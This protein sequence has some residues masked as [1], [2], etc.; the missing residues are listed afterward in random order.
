MARAGRGESPS[1]IHY[2]P[3]PGQYSLE[4]NPD[5]SKGAVSFPK[6]SRFKESSDDAV[7]GPGAHG[8]ANSSSF[9][10]PQSP[11]IVIGRAGRE[12]GPTSTAS[13]VPL[14]NP[15]V[16]A[17]KPTSPRQ[18]IGHARRFSQ[19]PDNGVPGP[20]YTLPKSPTGPAF[21]IRGER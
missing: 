3:G 21:T 20:A 4:Q 1:K 13:D 9:T 14:Y 2:S 19:S 11:R 10:R 5:H 12:S 7:P 16:S 6:D 17:V 18:L 8:G 15:G